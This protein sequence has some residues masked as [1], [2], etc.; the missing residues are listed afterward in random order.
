MQRN[1]RR[2][3]NL[4]KGRK[5][6]MGRRSYKMENGKMEE[7]VWQPEFLGN[8][9]TPSDGYNS[10]SQVG[11]PLRYWNV[12]N[13]NAEFDV[14]CGASW[15]MT[16]MSLR[17]RTCE[18]YTIRVQSLIRRHATRNYTTAKLENHA[19]NYDTPCHASWD[20]TGMSLKYHEKRG[21]KTMYDQ[22]P[23]CR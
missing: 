6:N 19:H 18:W 1:K 5:W 4:K 11:E 9:K 2:E 20:A 12:K 16:E 21:I 17:C 3:R 22:W 7:H 8:G 13:D 10:K 23:K 15:T 14:M